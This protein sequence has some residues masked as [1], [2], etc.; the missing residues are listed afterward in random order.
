MH[1]YIYIYIYISYVA[2]GNEPFL[3]SYNAS[4]VKST[5]P[6]LQNIQKALNKAGLGDKIKAVVPLNADVY[7]SPANKPLPS[8]G[9]F[10]QDIH[11][12]MVNIV[13]FLQSN[14]APFVVNI[15]PF[16]SLYNN[17]NFPKDFAF[18]NGN[19]RPIVD[20]GK[21][22]S[23]VFDANFDTLVWSLKKAGAGDLK[24]IVGEVG[25]PTNGDI[26]ANVANAKRFYDGLL[27]KLGKKQGTPIRPNPIEGYIFSLIDEDMKSVLPGSFERHWG[28]FTYD[29]KPKFSMDLS[30]KGMS[31]HLVPA[32]VK[33]LPFQWCVLKKD[34]KELYKLSGNM[35][36]ACS[37]GDCT[38]LGYGSSCNGLSKYENASYA[39]NMY[40][41]MQDQDVR[42]CDF[43]GIAEI[44]TKNAST[45]DCLFPIQ[46]ISSALPG[47]VPALGFVVGFA[48]FLVF[49]LF[50]SL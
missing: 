34:V 14:N 38:A 8:A 41:Q 9:D 26:N 47:Q 36:Y 23:N 19:A 4:F 44:V 50:G 20:S 24:I 12:L 15:Y 40:F 43:G 1:G 27:L 33:Y 31:K 29:G 16:L 35:D 18:F 22:Y 39:F 2:V 46:I 21:T 28:I 17:P 42:G 25:W 49:S 30:G 3:K 45:D 6:A 13:H 5:F 48:L 7:N 11:K 37:L 32:Q 10:R